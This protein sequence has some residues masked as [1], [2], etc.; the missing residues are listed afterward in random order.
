MHLHITHCL[1][2]GFGAFL[3]LFMAS[4][5]GSAPEYTLQVPPVPNAISANGSSSV[6]SQAK[7]VLTDMSKKT[8]SSAKSFGKIAAIYS[9]SECVIEGVRE[10]ER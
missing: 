10:R 7:A 2:F 1:G 6:R 8:W 9:G 4:M 3:G 5:S